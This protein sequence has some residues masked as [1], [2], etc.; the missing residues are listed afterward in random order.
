MSTPENQ[1]LIGDLTNDA[2]RLWFDD[3]VEEHP[4]YQALMILMTAGDREVDP[5]WL[6][7]EL[8]IEASK[9]DLIDDETF[10]MMVG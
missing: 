5:W 4:V 9:R 1:K 7:M 2:L 6:T 10:N 8:V 3:P